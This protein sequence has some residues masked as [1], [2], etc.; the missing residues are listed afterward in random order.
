MQ[1]HKPFVLN[2]LAPR[3]KICSEVVTQDERRFM[4]AIKSVRERNF[5]QTVMELMF[6]WEGQDASS[7]IDYIKDLCAVLPY[8]TSI[9]T[10]KHQE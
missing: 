6:L 9:C 2:F 3:S 4:A 7:F 1:K 10:T 5:R 8:G